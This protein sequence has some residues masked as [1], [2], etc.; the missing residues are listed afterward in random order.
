MFVVP[1]YTRALG[2]YTYR[3]KTIHGGSLGFAILKH[4]LGGEDLIDI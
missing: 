3:V 1:I 2:N 4:G